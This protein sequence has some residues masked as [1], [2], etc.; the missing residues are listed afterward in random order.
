MLATEVGRMVAPEETLV[1]HGGMQAAYVVFTS[2]V[3]VGDEIIIPSPCFFFHDMLRLTGG[4]P[5]LVPMSE[6]AEYRFDLDRI[7]AAITPRTKAI[8]VNT[9]VNPTGYVVTQ[10]DLMGI[11]AMAETHDL[12]IISDESFDKFIYDGRKHR[13]MA[14]LDDADSRT[15]TI[16]SFTKSYGLPP[17]RVGYIFATQPRIEVCQKVLEWII[18]TSNYVSQRVALAALQGPK[19]WLSGVCGKFQHNRDLLWEGL[20]GI[21]AISCIKPQGG[22]FLLPNI[23][24]FSLSE[25]ELAWKLLEEY[26]IPTTP[27]VY[28]DAPGHVRIPFGGITDAQIADI[29]QRIRQ[30]A[31]CYA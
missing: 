14:A 22:P 17:W 31:D 28:F 27:G 15:I 8:L 29:A 7:E 5:V 10:E 12:T 19:D 30:A 11:A 13:M 21:D 26:E 24:R 16:R 6:E 3:D 4:V 25:E 20:S 18:L 1:T 9:P 2:L 23:S